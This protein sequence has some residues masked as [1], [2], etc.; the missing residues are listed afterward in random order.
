M[1]V[2]L[3]KIAYNGEKFHGVVPQKNV[4]TILNEII[5]FYKIKNYRYSITSRTDKGVSAKE[6]YL[7]LQTE[8][9]IDL[10]DFSHNSI[11]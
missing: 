6:N 2:Y 3:L 4:K 9:E 7:V 8:N 10:T 5:N 1:A 11:K